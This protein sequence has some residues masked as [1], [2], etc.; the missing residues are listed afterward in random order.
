MGRKTTR[1][2]FLTTNGAGLAMLTLGP[3]VTQDEEDMPTIRPP[4]YATVLFDGKDLSAWVSRNGKAAG[5]KIEKDYAEV[6][7]GSGDI[8]TKQTFT[9]FQLH[10][11]FCLPL[12][13]DARGQARAN[14]GVYLQGRY[15]IQVL[16]SY[17]LESKNNDCGAF[18]LIAAPLKNACKKP[19]KWQ[20]YDIAFRTARFDGAG[21]VKEFARATVFHN[22][23]M[24]HNN[25]EL[26]TATKGGLDEDTSKP[27]PILLQD[28]RDKVRYRNVWMIPITD[29][30]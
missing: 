28:H 22:G 18:Y 29:N 25:L 4:K 1:R 10:V 3:T 16:D 17:G 21:K 12:M 9:D 2:H 8:Y 13:A 24:I 19:E 27:G 11:E 5:W 15:E 7:A 20:S 23:V 6:V 26:P 30:Q 14:S